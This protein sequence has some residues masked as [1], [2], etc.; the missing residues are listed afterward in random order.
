MTGEALLTERG[1]SQEYNCRVGPVGLLKAGCPH[2]RIGRLL[3]DCRR[4]GTS[5]S[6]LSI[7]S[8]FRQEK[9]A[10]RIHVVATSLLQCCSR[11]VHVT[12]RATSMSPV[13]PNQT[14]RH[15]QAGLRLHFL[16]L[17]GLRGVVKTSLFCGRRRY[18]CCCNAETLKRP[19]RPVKLVCC[20]C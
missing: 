19:L 6:G 13:E 9:T 18:R 11:Y 10:L 16:S 5:P 3:Q 7:S 17:N 20:F 14:W 1:T 4:C 2:F 12:S 15:S 8:E